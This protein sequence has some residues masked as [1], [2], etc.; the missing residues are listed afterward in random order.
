[1]L[2]IT[3]IGSSL[4]FINLIFL[5]DEPYLY[6]RHNLLVEYE[7]KG[8]L[9]NECTEEFAQASFMIRR[10]SYL[11]RASR[12]RSYVSMVSSKS[13]QIRRP[14][15]YPSLAVGHAFILVNQMDAIRNF[16]KIPL[17]HMSAS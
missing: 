13:F 7:E 3:G 10:E 4:S 12:M 9:L 2:L 17:I 6:K 16:L 5:S 15:I 1:M 11:K 14:L 8:P